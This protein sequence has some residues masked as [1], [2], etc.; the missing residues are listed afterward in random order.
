MDSSY[1][2]NNLSFLYESSD[3]KK[4]AV[5]SIDTLLFTYTNKDTF[6]NNLVPSTFFNNID[7]VQLKREKVADVSARSGEVDEGIKLPLTTDIA[8]TENAADSEIRVDIGRGKQMPISILTMI[9]DASKNVFVI[10]NAS[11]SHKAYDSYMRGILSA[12]CSYCMREALR[13][14]Y[15]IPNVTTQSLLEGA[16]ILSEGISNGK[17]DLA[18]NIVS[19]TSRKCLIDIL[20]KYTK[21]RTD[22]VS[23][24]NNTSNSFTRPLYYQLRSDMLTKLYL[25]TNVIPD[26]EDYPMLYIKRIVVDTYIKTCYPLLHYDFME[27]MMQK[28]ADSGD[29]VNVRIALLAKIFFV[30]Y[31]VDYI[32]ENI[33]LPDNQLTASKKVEFQS[34]INVINTNLNNY[35]V[36]LNNIN[37]SSTPGKNELADIISSLHKLSAD[38]VQKSQNSETLKEEIRTNQLALRNV[39]SNSED[40]QQKYKAKVFEFV[41]NVVLVI[42]FV[43]VCGVLLVFNKPKYV[44]YVAGAVIVSVLLVKLVVMIKKLLGKN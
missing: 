34:I 33:F 21:I 16:Q 43:I 22:I 36:S 25:P 8:F 40:M 32:R 9:N 14:V 11:K 20:N 19:E 39:I 2:Q 44:Y 30:H 23:N 1:Y 15:P 7:T 17:R 4:P 10:N 6:N 24:F 35:L 3:K 18:F 5:Y 29:F 31:F 28:Y 13:R 26:M 37:M 27:A 12:V 42:L 41:F 38:V